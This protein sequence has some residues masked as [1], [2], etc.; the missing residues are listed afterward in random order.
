MPTGKNQTKEG[1]NRF[2]FKKEIPN[3]YLIKRDSLDFKDK[4]NKRVVETEFSPYLG[5]ISA[6]DGI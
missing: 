4:E 3:V 6:P 1:E 5:I 2:Y